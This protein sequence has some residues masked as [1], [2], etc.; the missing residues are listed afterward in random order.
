MNSKQKKALKKLIDNAHKEANKQLKK[1][2]GAEAILEGGTKKGSSRST[3]LLFS[4]KIMREPRCMK[5]LDV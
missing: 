5:E 2:Y 3:S 4:L 1:T